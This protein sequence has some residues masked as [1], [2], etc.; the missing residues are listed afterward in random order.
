[1]FLAAV[2]A[3]R[4]HQEQHPV[5]D[6]V[7]DANDQSI[8]GVLRTQSAQLLHQARR[9]YEPRTEDAVIEVDE[10]FSS[11]SEA[12]IVTNETGGSLSD[13]FRDD[14]RQEWVDAVFGRDFFRSPGYQPKRQGVG[15]SKIASYVT[16]QSTIPEDVATKGERVGATLSR[17]ALGLYVRRVERGSEAAHAGVREGSILVDVNGMGFLGEPS[18]HAL[19]RLWQYEGYRDDTEED[20]LA[21]PAASSSSSDKEPTHF[22]DRPVAMKFIKGGELYTVL[23]L[24]NPPFGIS[25]APC[26]N[27]A[28]VQRSYSFASDAGVLRGSLVAAVN[29]L[30]M[31]V[32]D[33][34]SA[35]NEISRLFREGKQIELTLGFTPAAA[36]TGLFDRLLTERK[37]GK[38]SPPKEKRKIGEIDGVEVRYHPLEYNLG[39]LFHGSK[40]VESKKREGKLSELASL[41]AAGEAE[42]P[43]GLSHS[44]SNLSS[45]TG[46]STTSQRA[47][48]KTYQPCPSLSRDELLRKWDP[49]DALLFLSQMEC[50]DYD[51]DAV[52]ELIA[53]TVETAPLS[54]LTAMTEHEDGWEVANALILQWVSMLCVFEEDEVEDED[55][56]ESE[57][58]KEMAALLLSM[59]SENHIPIAV[60][61][62]CT[63]RCNG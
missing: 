23:F 1:M 56:G 48:G 36:R 25:W 46:S 55:V 21:N 43:V 9:C 22:T 41:V 3:Y 62:T 51:E 54:L 11:M 63:Q 59:V 16:Y 39:S 45:S 60:L 5:E 28:L 27:F 24:S 14:I 4:Y 33:H 49:L 13:V 26:G 57:R 15:L 32:L 44:R 12:A 38:K 19:E 2:L 61:G 31:R 42:A 35:A 6:T 10:S 34:Q 17:I 58:C 40:K 52:A 37:Q 47:L 18:K 53:K 30:S 50:S 8:E 29:G 7:D 20:G